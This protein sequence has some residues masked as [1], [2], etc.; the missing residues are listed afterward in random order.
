MPVMRSKSIDDRSPSSVT[1]RKPAGAFNWSTETFGFRII[2]PAGKTDIAPGKSTSLQSVKIA[3]HPALRAKAGLISSATTMRSDSSIAAPHAAC[4]NSFLEPFDFTEGTRSSNYLDILELLEVQNADSV[5]PQTPMVLK[6]DEADLRDVIPVGYDE[7]E[8]IYFPLGFSNDAGELIIETLP[9]A[10]PADPAIT[11]RSFG[12][13][14]KIYFQK[15][16]GRKLGFAY[17]YP[18]LAIATVDEELGVQYESDSAKVS[19]AIGQAQNILLFVHG[20]IGDTESM[21]K[22]VRLRTGE[23]NLLQKND[24]ILSFDYE[25]LQTTIEE[26]ATFLKQRLMDSG[27]TEGHTKNLTIVAHSMGGLVSRWFIEKLGGNKITSRLVMLGTPN[28]GTPWAD[29][30]DMAETLLTYAMNGAAFLKPWMF[31]LNLAGKI[32]SGTQVTLKQMD[33]DTGIYKALNDGTDPMIPYTIIAGNT[34]DIIPDYGKTASLLNR[35]FTRIRKRGMYDA[36][37]VV[38]FREANDIA[39]TNKSIAEVGNAANWKFQPKV[40]YVAS[41]HMNYFNNHAA[42]SKI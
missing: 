26:N 15:V 3:A 13:S 40:T 34:R 19:A 9:E 33:K 29:V 8:G 12:G 23:S 18:R 41:D 5:T 25:N 27:L 10:T 37:D 36:L 38:L 22:C 14:I 20:I 11:S 21:V 24:L 16:I 42:L 32:T 17:N 30:R 39:V 7:K 4:Q 2:R 1:A 35:I 31:V 6:V 28:N